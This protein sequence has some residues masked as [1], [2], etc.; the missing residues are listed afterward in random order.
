MKPFHSTALTGKYLAELLP[1]Y[2]KEM[3]TLHQMR[4]D[5]ILAFWPKLIGEKLAPMT[6]AFSF[7]SGI[8]TVKVKNS[9][10]YSLLVQ[11]EKS[12]LLKSLKNQFPSVPIRDI[13]F[14]IGQ[15]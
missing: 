11:N 2:L 10:L 12:K 3:K 13:Y 6:R 8:L 14:R 4:P 5:L 1:K 15:F 9:T 7:E